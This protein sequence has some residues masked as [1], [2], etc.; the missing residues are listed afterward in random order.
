[1]ALGSSRF[2]A[3]F[4]CCC[5]WRVEA[6]WALLQEQHPELVAGPDGRKASRQSNGN[7]I[8]REI[9]C[10]VAAASFHR[11]QVS[12]VRGEGV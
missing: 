9:F 12:E 5:C 8:K 4:C 10:R 11:V 1:M 7:A 3:I 6:V 2:A